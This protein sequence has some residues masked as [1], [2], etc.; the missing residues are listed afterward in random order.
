MS[1]LEALMKRYDEL[2]PRATGFERGF[3]RADA[4]RVLGDLKLV[5]ITLTVPAKLKPRPAERVAGISPD[6]SF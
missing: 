5:G 1:P 2:H 6:D 4:L 3:Y